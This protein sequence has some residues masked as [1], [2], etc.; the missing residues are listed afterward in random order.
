MKRFKTSVITK[1]PEC[2]L[3]DETEINGKTKF[4]N[5][6]QR[7][8]KRGERQIMMKKKWITFVLTLIIILSRCAGIFPVSA[9]DTAALSPEK[10]AARIFAGISTE[11]KPARMMSIAFR[12]DP[13]STG[14]AAEIGQS[15][16]ELPE[17]NDFERIPFQGWL[18]H[19]I[20][21]HSQPDRMFTEERMMFYD[22]ISFCGQIQRGSWES[23]HSRA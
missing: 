5:N 20:L 6:Y 17:K 8:K 12:S 23:G 2:F 7:Q 19:V 9:A 1:T 16:R 21:T 14:N 22:E 13:Q 11:Q 3:S 10:Q 4:Q 18:R 15:Y